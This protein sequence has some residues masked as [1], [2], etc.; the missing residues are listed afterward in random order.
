[1]NDFSLYPLLL[2]QLPSDDFQNVPF[3]STEGGLQGHTLLADVTPTPPQ[4]YFQPSPSTPAHLSVGKHTTFRKGTKLRFFFVFLTQF[5]TFCRNFCTRQFLGKSANFANNLKNEPFEGRDDGHK[6]HTCSKSSSRPSKSS[7]FKLFAKFADFLK[8]S[9]SPLVQKFRQ[10]SK[11]G[12]KKKNPPILSLF[13]RL[14]VY[15][16]T[17]EGR[18]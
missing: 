15:F 9:L 13:E 12:A 4:P 18:E 3:C 7:F 11:I 5:W 10:R 14:C 2:P 6:T 17:K 1:M 8:N 16:P